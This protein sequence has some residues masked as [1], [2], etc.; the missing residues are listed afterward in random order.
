MM[1]VVYWCA[2]GWS[3]KAP[4][5]KYSDYYCYC[6]N[7]TLSIIINI[8]IVIIIIIIMIKK[9][10]LP[11]LQWRVVFRFS[12]EIKSQSYPNYL[13]Q[14]KN[15]TDRKHTSWLKVHTS[16]RTA[17][18]F[19]HLLYLTW[20]RNTSAMKQAENCFAA[21]IKCNKINMEELLILQWLIKK[22]LIIKQVFYWI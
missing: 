18:K 15:P 17:K 4:R 5:L 8:I 14:I 6:C 2:C 21:L 12:T 11:Y 16:T 10:L 20:T 9:M 19:M 22:N 7:I 1:F 13:K 3:Q